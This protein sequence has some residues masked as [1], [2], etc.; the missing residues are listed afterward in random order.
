MVTGPRDVPFG[1]RVKGLSSALSKYQ[2]TG[3]PSLTVIRAPVQLAI[4]Y[5]TTL[6]VPELRMSA[7]T[8]SALVKLKSPV[9][10]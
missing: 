2:G 7:R 6:P 8:S 1:R 4:S 10:V 5:R 3:T 9:T